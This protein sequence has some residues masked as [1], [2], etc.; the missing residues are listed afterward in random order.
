MWKAIAAVIKAWGEKYTVPF[1]ISVTVAVAVIIVIPSDYWMIEKVGLLLFGILVACVVFLIVLFIRYCFGCIQRHCTDRNNNSILTEQKKNEREQYLSKLW[2][3][4]DGFSPE[5]RKTIRTLV[6][7]GNQPIPR[8]S[9]CVYSCDSFWD[10]ELVNSTTMID[11]Q[12]KIN[13]MYKL[14]DDIYLCLKFSMDKYNRISD[15]D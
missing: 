14:K 15:F 13:E 4:I 10:S 6:N 11:E 9:R 12:G 8:T 7:T 2:Q 3:R 5:E 1:V